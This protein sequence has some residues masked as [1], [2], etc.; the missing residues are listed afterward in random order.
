M[1]TK[2]IQEINNIVR[3]LNSSISGLTEKNIACRINHIKLYISSKTDTETDDGN[4]VLEV[5]VN[6]HIDDIK[7]DIQD[8]KTDTKDQATKI[9]DKENLK[10]LNKKKHDINF[11]KN[12]AEIIETNPVVID[13]ENDDQNYD[14]LVKKH[15]FLTKKSDIRAKTNKKKAG[16][17]N[18]RNDK[19]EMKGINEEDTV[20]KLLE[21]LNSA[22][23]VY[24]GETKEKPY[25]SSEEADY[26]DDTMENS[27]D[28]RAKSYDIV[29]KTDDIMAKPYDI[30]TKL[31][32]ILANLNDDLTLDNDDE[33]NNSL[34]NKIKVIKIDD[35]QNNRQKEILKRK[36]QYRYKYL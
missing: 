12:E 8:H 32:D 25:D 33:F 18:N 13:N 1:S 27:Y 29:A 31:Y 6:E 7:N 21:I 10:P 9:Q 26:Y 28:T 11:E 24:G 22:I 35:S 3:D 23:N 5:F 14:Y 2:E 16:K 15:D 17:Q 36:P 30:T 34:I 19:T 4:T 20:K